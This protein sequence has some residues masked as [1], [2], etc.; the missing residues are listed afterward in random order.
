MEVKKRNKSTKILKLITLLCVVF[1]VC[2]LLY[3]KMNYHRITYGENVRK[4][5]KYARTGKMVEVETVLVTDAYLE[6]FV[7]SEE[8]EALSEGMYMFR[9][10][11]HDVDIKTDIVTVDAPYDLMDS[12]VYFEAR[13]PVKVIYHRMRESE[14]MIET[15]D[16]EIIKE[17][18]GALY[19]ILISPT[20]TDHAVEDYTDVVTLVFE[21]DSR[22][23]Y[24]FEENYYISPENNRHYPV[25]QGLDRLRSVL[26]QMI[27]NCQ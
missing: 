14:D 15:E 7:N 20:S 3:F 11:D 18:T 1:A 9:M 23:S 13:T 26:E 8:I 5:P 12:P 25:T 19:I 24:E 4:C 27:E 6:L 21:D 17:I 10:P 22:Q 2:G 16:P